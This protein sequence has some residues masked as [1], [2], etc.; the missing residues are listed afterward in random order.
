V[1]QRAGVPAV[2]VTL[3]HWGFAGWGG[4]CCI[5]FVAAPSADKP[6]L[7]LLALAP[8]PV[9]WWFVRRRAIA[10]RIGRW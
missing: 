10:A 2:T 5:A 9:W 1:A 4:L 6:Y 3:I 7:P 8:Q